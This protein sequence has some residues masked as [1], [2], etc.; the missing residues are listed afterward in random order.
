MEYFSNIYGF[1]TI[2]AIVAE[3]SAF[4]NSKQVL[5]QQKLHFFWIFKHWYLKNGLSNFAQ[6]Y[7]FHRQI[8]PNAMKGFI[9]KYKDPQKLML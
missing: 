7:H 6:W 2:R 5:T 9:L 1:D 8:E 3:I 4:E